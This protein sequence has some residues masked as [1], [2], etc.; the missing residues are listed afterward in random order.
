MMGK[1][2]ISFNI[3]ANEKTEFNVLQELKELPIVK[4]TIKEPKTLSPQF[5]CRFIMLV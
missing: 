1:K 4:A 3:N 2:N 5:L